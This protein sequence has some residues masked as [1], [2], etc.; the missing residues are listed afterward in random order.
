MMPVTT[1]TL[2]QQ[3]A[4]YVAAPMELFEHPRVVTKTSSPA[5]PALP[6]GVFLLSGEKAER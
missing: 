3:V 5:C 4:L 6:G 2:P 1:K